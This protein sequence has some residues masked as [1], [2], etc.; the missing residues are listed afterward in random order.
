MTYKEKLLDPR[1]QKKRLEILDR[2]S[3]MCRACFS[4]T[5][6]LHV[7]HKRYLNGKDPWDYDNNLLVTLCHECHD[8]ETKEM[9]DAIHDLVAVIKEKFFSHHIRLLTQ[10]FIDYETPYI[11]DANAASIKKFLSEAG[12]EMVEAYFNS[13]PKDKNPF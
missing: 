4:T 12:P 13:L 8:I 7:H 1:W 3:F 5:K 2:D 11:E 6:T 10:G 9:E